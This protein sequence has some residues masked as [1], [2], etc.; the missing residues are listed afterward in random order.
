MLSLGKFVTIGFAVLI[1]APAVSCLAPNPSPVSF[2]AVDAEPLD[3]VSREAL[4]LHDGWYLGQ[5][6]VV[7]GNG[8]R[9]S[10]PAFDPVHWYPTTVPTTVLGA[11]VRLGVYPDPYVAGNNDKIPDASDPGSPWNKPWWFRRAFVLPARGRRKIVWL[12]LDGINYRAEV[13]VN[14]E[15]IAGEQDAVGMFRRFRFNISDVVRPGR[16]N[17][18][19]IRIFPDDVAGIP[20]YREPGSDVRFQ[21]NVTEMS[22][23]GWDWV[24]PA[25]DRNMGLWQEVWIERSGPVVVQDP[26]A[27]T[28]VQLPDG[29][30]AEITVRL[31]VQN[32]AGETRKADIS[33]EIRPDGFSGPPIIV[34]Q[35]VQ[36]PAE[37]TQEVMF[38]PREFPSLIMH[39]PHLWWPHG[40]GAQPLYRLSVTA[41]VCGQLS[42]RNTADFGVRS[43][44]YF[45]RPVQF[46]HKL[47]PVPDG[48]PPYS[49]PPLET[50][51]IFT[52]NGRPIRLVGGSMVPDFLLTWSAQHYRDQVRLM[53]EGNQT[54][55]RVWGGGIIMPDVFYDEADRRG[56]LV[57]QDLVR[58]SFTVAWGKK[59]GEI[60][61]VDKEAYLANMQD[62]ILRLRG[63]TSL[64][65]WCGINESA[66]PIDIG[67][68][69]QNDL[70]PKLDGTRPWLPSTSTEPIWAI[71]PLGMRSFGPYSIQPIRY[72]FDQY[73]HSP[74]FLFKNEIG[75]ESEP[76]FNSILK[77]I[78]GAGA[79]DARQSWDTQVLR[80]H[81]LPSRTLTPFMIRT[82]GKPL[83][84]ADFS[85]MAQ[86]LSAQS[87][88]AIFDAANK[89]R[90]RNPGTM[91]W[92]TNAAWLDC[93]F[94]LY[95]WYLRPTAG[96]YAVKA[97]SR[98]LHV[99]YAADDHTLSVV[100]LLPHPVDVRIRATLTSALGVQQDVKDYTL[101]SAADATT[102]AGPAPL[103]I[104]D[105]QLHF[106]ALNLMDTRG[107]EL[108]RLVTWVQNDECWSSLLALPP[109]SVTASMISTAHPHPGEIQYQVEVINHGAVPAVQAWVEVID[110]PLGHEVLPSFWSYNAFSMLPGEHRTITVSFRGSLQTKRHL[111]LMVEGFNVTPA[112]FGIEHGDVPAPIRAEVTSL[113]QSSQD[114]RR[115]IL[116]DVKQ[117]GETGPR[118]TLWPLS[119][120]VDGRL[121][122]TFRVALRS[123]D[124]SEVEIPADLLRGGQTVQAGDL[125]LAINPQ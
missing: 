89:N 44:G 22:A 86:M 6:S 29:R 107:H 48:E 16:L 55:V 109:V 50:A 7:G 47:N 61:K 75:L 82:L 90:S 111:R 119:L 52:V 72:Y 21:Q 18:L 98:K 32:A 103:D 28:K 96:Y 117:T 1:C 37:A 124:S 51:R 11:L 95:D 10:D 39:H 34:H 80:D 77:A 70:L 40:Y 59:E 97:A 102:V 73:A 60:P 118:T 76:A 33:A 9:F 121:L 84:L 81:G 92:M 69:L 30:K 24:P 25:R 125:K 112:E 71:E 57:W 94:Q 36:I 68:A 20:G 65:A 46:A 63:R 110:G 123:G 26:A 2:K 31:M 83:S 67:L 104:A 53:T 35:L 38:T 5:E 54:I 115:V 4:I 116:V 56:L 120:N 12:H 106:L 27:Y 49:Y 85:T 41:S 108:D 19:A 74:D 88:G 66:E 17:A 23:L 58:T 122:R 100:S 13:W 43:I 91:V 105:G 64:L 101:T 14:G 3:H 78:P 15:K 99:F 87:F 8:A 93:M 45:Y 114:G 79:I 42:D 113:K 62:A